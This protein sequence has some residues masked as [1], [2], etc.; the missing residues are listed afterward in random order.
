[1]HSAVSAG[2]CEE[3]ALGAPASRPSVGRHTLQRGGRG[4]RSS[5]LG[6]CGQG[7][8]GRSQDFVVWALQR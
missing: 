2:E 5:G 7:A 8:K 4:E 6:G 3:G 1:M